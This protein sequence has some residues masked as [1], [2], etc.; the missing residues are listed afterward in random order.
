MDNWREQIRNSI[1]KTEDLCQYISLSEDEKLA[2][3]N[4]KFQITPYMMKLITQYDQNDVLRK[5]FIPFCNDST[6]YYSA[7]YLNELKFQPVPNLI[8]KYKNRVI[9]TITNKCA[10]YCQFCTRQRL[11]YYDYHLGFDK[12]KILNYIQ[13]NTAINDVLIT[14]GDPLMMETNELI[15]LIDSIERINN[16]KVIRIG[17][18]I[19]ITLPMRIDDELVNA[20]QKYNNLYINIH[21]N[22]P[23]ELTLESRN[24]ILNLANAGIPL[25][26]Q[27]VL[28]KGIND[29][30]VTL[31]KL[32]EEL[33]CIKVKPYYLYQCDKVRGCEGYITDPHKGIM[34][35][36]QLSTEISGF[37]L[38]KFVIDTPEA[39][40]M[41]LAPCNLADCQSNAIYMKMEHKDIIYY[42][43]ELSEK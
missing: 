17:T 39:G 4:K 11:T 29:N 20:L 15:A 7:D 22:H 16:V 28:L 12:E 34:L 33:I 2:L 37:A 30:A 21:V 36:N 31:K 26:S 32:F 18:R 27:S 5:Q 3:Q 23:S 8:H 40:K 24:A 35:I 6:F 13:E 42:T 1:T 14:G 19:P 43:D 41:I 10:C 38:P 25:G 9:I